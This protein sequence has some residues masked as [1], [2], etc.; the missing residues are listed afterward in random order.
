MKLVGELVLD[1]NR[2]MR[3][4]GEITQNMQPN[5]YTEELESVASSIDK[6]VGDL[7]TCRNENENAACK[8]TVPEIHKSCKRPVKDCRKRS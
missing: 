8:K 2:L 6:I 7:A 1:R 5:K 3:V 4:V